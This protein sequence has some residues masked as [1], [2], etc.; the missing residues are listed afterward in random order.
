[1]PVLARLCC[2]N[3]R[4]NQMKNNHEPKAVMKPQQKSTQNDFRYAADICRER[5][6]VV[7]TRIVADFATGPKTLEITAIGYRIIL[8]CS[9]G[10]PGSEQ[11]WVL[12]SRDWQDYAVSTEGTTK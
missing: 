6:W 12:D 8:A 7:G 1:M 4:N 9:I 3:E 10:R 5:G 2:S 11:P